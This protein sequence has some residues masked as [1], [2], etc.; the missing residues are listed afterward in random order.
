MS[1]AAEVGDQSLVYKF[2]SLASNAATWSTRAAF[3]RFG[4]SNILAESDIDPKLYPKL[5]RYRL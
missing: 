1:L 5:Y 3:G 2:M 4:L